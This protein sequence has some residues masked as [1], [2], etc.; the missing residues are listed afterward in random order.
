[1]LKKILIIFSFVF[2][3]AAFA[4]EAADKVEFKRLYAEFNDLY[5]NSE[6]L[7]PIIEVAE[8]LYELAPSVYGKTL[9]QYAVTMYNLASLYH[10]KGESSQTFYDNYQYLQ[11]SNLGKKA[12]EYYERYFEIID[13]FNEPYDRSYFDQFYKFVKA[14]TLFNGYESVTEHSHKLVL[15][16][17]DIN[18]SPDIQA[19]LNY[20]LG[21]LRVKAW[22]NISAKPFFEAAYELTMASK[23]NDHILIGKS[24]YWLGLMAAGEEDRTL[25]EKFFLQALKVLPSEGEE[26]RDTVINIHFGLAH[27]Y[28]IENRLDEAAKHGQKYAALQQLD[29]NEAIVITKEQPEFPRYVTKRYRDEFVELEF[30]LDVDGAPQD[31]L[32]AESSRDL[33]NEPCIEAFKNFRFLPGWDNGKR[34][35]VKGKK[36]KFVFQY[37][38]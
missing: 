4:D 16:A 27:L 5:A 12:V 19:T 8:K 24:A 35:E 33:L 2:S 25:A 32:V 13:A 14:D 17:Q 31:I 1:M 28:F 11:H 30:T 3:T 29:G 21:T 20:E 38:N 6:E 7:D 36:Y 34:I 22:Q 37:R 23:G 9:K 18:L 15:I 10:E 26:G